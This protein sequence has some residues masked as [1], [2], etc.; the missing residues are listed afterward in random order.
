MSWRHA[1]LFICSM[2][3]YL[4]PPCYPGQGLLFCWVLASQRE[5]CCSIVLRGHRV[6]VFCLFGIKAVKTFFQVESFGVIVSIK[7]STYWQRSLLRLYVNSVLGLGL[8][9]TTSQTRIICTSKNWMYAPNSISN[10]AILKR[11]NAL[12]NY[13]NPKSIN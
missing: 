5:P 4:D 10:F 1:T 11:V 13:P 9:S 8:C 6:N 7:Q 12:K 2:D 3:W